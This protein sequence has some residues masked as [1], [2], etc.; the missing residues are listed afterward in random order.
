MD[1]LRLDRQ[2]HLRVLTQQR[3][4][5]KESVVIH[6]YESVTFLKIVVRT[7]AVAAGGEVGAI[8]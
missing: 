8:R 5:A 2:S 6:A 3:I 1:G 7:V 4:E